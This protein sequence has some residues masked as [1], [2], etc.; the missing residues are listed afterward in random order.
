M[1]ATMLPSHAG[2]GTAE[3]T[4]PRCDVDAESCLV[5]VLLSHADNDATE[6]TWSWRDVDVDSCWQWCY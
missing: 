1:L 2:D 6:A 3:V 5:M 4:W